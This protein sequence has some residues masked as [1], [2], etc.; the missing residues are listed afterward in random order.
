MQK[1]T[2]VPIIKD[3]CILYHLIYVYNT[4][5]L[6]A[7]GK[8]ISDIIIKY[9]YD[10]KNISGARIINNLKEVTDELDSFL[11]KPTNIA[12]ILSCKY[13]NHSTPSRLK[14]LAN[15]LFALV[16]YPVVRACLFSFTDLNDALGVPPPSNAFQEQGWPYLQKA[17][18]EFLFFINTTVAIK[19]EDGGNDDNNNNYKWCSRSNY[20]NDNLEDDNKK[21]SDE[22][23]IIYEELLKE[24]KEIEFFFNRINLYD[25]LNDFCI[26]G[27]NIN[28]L[29]KEMDTY[30]KSL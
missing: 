20:I 6:R 24:E 4:K 19:D 1:K 10:V 18:L 21:D 25:V 12:K 3:K 22:Y 26:D 23:G 7:I 11:Y 13:K 28:D 16:F 5:N 29:K 30:Y 9:D 15:I 17:I 14:I 27:K 2:V 8:M